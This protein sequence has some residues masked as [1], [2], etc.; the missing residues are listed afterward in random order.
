MS[1]ISPLINMKYVY[2]FINELNTRKGV[3]MRLDKS[4]MK[5]VILCT[6]FWVE[7]LLE[8]LT[9]ERLLIVNWM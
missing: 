8:S 9:Q 7:A 5:G 4:T 3:L 2:N 1:E 6:R